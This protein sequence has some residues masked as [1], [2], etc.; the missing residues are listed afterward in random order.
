[1]ESGKQK[2]DGGREEVRSCV[3]EEGGGG[4]W[5]GQGGKGCSAAR[6]V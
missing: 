6:W 2:S 3:V 5:S 1:M 4:A